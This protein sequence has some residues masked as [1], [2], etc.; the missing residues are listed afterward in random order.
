M[1]RSPKYFVR[2]FAAGSRLHIVL[3]N[4]TERRRGSAA[5][6]WLRADE[7]AFQSCGRREKHEHLECELHRRAVACPEKQAN[8]REGQAIPRKRIPHKLFAEEIF[9]VRAATR[10]R[11]CE[12]R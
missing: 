5:K 8:R 11:H 7:P 6:C 4:S 3:P 2:R 1:D 10:V 9:R 12:R